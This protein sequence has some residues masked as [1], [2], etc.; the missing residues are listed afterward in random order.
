[1]RSSTT[2]RTNCKN[3][4]RMKVCAGGEVYPRVENFR[5]LGLGTDG[6]G[7]IHERLMNVHFR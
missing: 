6:C 7:V 4:D 2:S 3:K 5:A 1:M